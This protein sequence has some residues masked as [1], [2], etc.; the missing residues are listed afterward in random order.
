MEH[1]KIN[2]KKNILLIWPKNDKFITFK[3]RSHGLESDRRRPVRS[4]RRP[5]VSGPRQPRQRP[6]LGRQTIRE[7]FQV[8]RHLH[9]VSLG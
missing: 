1:T 3:G 7:R 4:A 8:G 5:P 6:S 9:Q 2:I